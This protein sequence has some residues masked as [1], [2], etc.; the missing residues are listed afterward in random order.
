VILRLILLLFLIPFAAWGAPKADWKFAEARLKKAKLSKTFI[1][2]LK[3]IYEAKDFEQTVELNVLLFL[4]KHDDHGAQ[5]SED[6]VTTVKAFITANRASLTAAEKEHG[7]SG[8]VIASLLWMESRHGV[9]RGRF[10]VPSV[11][12]H[13]LQLTR[14]E[15]VA[16]LK[17]ASHKFAS[18]VQPSRLAEIKGRATKKA[19]WAL[20]ELRAL[21][22]MHHRDRRFVRELRGSFAGAF[23]IPQ[24]V[25]SSY[26]RWARSRNKTSTPDLNRTQDAIQSVA[27]YLKDNGWRKNKSKTYEKALLRYNNSQDYAR[28]ILKIARRIDGG[29][30]VPAGGKR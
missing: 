24:F 29:K 30:R 18:G 7:V 10:H 17:Q 16:H 8:S 28:A 1:A 25:P 13:L 6:A 15:V 19:D 26:L 22:K 11:Y 3:K 27:Y 9:N 14:P 12:V 5:V 4:R 20:G 23:G 2:D 21:E